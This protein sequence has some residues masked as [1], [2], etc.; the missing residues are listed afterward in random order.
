W[1]SEA[2]D[3]V[4]SANGRCHQENLLAHLHSGVRALQAPVGNLVSDWAYMGMTALAW[5]L[6]AWWALW[7][8]EP[9]GRWAGGHP[10]E[11]QW[12]LHIEVKTVL[13]AFMRPTCEVVRAG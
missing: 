10:A 5:D 3:I 2:N 6:K 4:F 9:P 12:A 13:N 7:L 1:L 8:P 11:E